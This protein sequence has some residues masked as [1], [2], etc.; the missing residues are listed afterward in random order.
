MYSAPGFSWALTESGAQLES[1]TPVTLTAVMVCDFEPLFC[2]HTVSP[3]EMVTGLGVK[4]CWSVAEITVCAPVPAQPF[5]SPDGFPHA[6]ARAT[7]ATNPR[8][9]AGDMAAG[10]PQCP[11]SR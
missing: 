3:A 6:S 1:V 8:T 5:P 7:P 2:Q 10:T 9:F 4:T 11:C